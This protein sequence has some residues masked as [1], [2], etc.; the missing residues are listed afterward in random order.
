MEASP[1]EDRSSFRQSVIRTAV[2]EKT[3]CSLPLYCDWKEHTMPERLFG[4]MKYVMD[5]SLAPVGRI[6]G[7]RVGVRNDLH[8][9]SHQ[10]LFWKLAFNERESSED[11][12]TTL[13]LRVAPTDWWRL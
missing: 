3:T 10:N 5:V 13:I 1:S 12:R 11:T 9:P 8:L 6:S 4:L 2:A 7:G